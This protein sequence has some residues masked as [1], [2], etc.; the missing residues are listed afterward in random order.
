[1]IVNFE[2]TD[3][4]NRQAWRI[5][6]EIQ[7]PDFDGSISRGGESK[8]IAKFDPGDQPEMCIIHRTQIL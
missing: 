4:P 7:M 3:Q 5:I 8:S 1:M 2:G 6:L